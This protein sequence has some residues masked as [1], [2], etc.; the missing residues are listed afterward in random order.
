MIGVV[1]EVSLFVA[2]YDVVLFEASV[3]LEVVDFEVSEADVQNGHGK[4]V[5]V[6]D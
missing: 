3:D 2:F 4:V 1:V 5:S 6:W